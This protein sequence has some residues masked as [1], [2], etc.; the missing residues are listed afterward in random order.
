MVAKAVSARRAHGLGRVVEDRWWS[1]QGE[2]APVRRI[3]TA[4]LS[5]LHPSGGLDA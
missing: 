1:K 5:R 3:L 2:V 4:G